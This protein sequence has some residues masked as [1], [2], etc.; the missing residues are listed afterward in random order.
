MSKYNSDHPRLCDCQSCQHWEAVEFN[1]L[2][3]EESEGETGYYS[4]RAVETS[5]GVSYSIKPFGV[6]HA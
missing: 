3:V 4:F 6:Y 1:S 2:D 5:T